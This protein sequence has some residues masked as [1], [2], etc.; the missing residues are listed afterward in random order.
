MG[1][2]TVFDIT[3]LGGV[4]NT[5]AMDEALD[6]DRVGHTGCDCNERGFGF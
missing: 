1:G 2:Q 4:G 3:T 5:I 6:F